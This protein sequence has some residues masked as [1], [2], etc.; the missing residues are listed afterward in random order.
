VKTNKFLV[1]CFVLFLSFS[2]FAEDTSTPCNPETAATCK[3]VNVKNEVNVRVQ[4]DVKILAEGTPVDLP[5]VPAELEETPNLS[6]YLTDSF[7]SLK[8]SI[9]SGFT[10]PT[11][12]GVCPVGS[13]YYL[14]KSLRLNAHCT[15]FDSSRNTLSTVLISVYVF[16]GLVIVLK[17]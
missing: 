16:L 4:G 12:V 6:Q 17:A 11:D 7:I 1:S 15:I 3:D 2:S 9:T 13:I 10:P 8:Q 14:N 5:A